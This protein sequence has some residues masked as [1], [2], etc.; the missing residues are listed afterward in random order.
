[1]ILIRGDSNSIKIN[2]TKNGVPY[3][4]QDLKDGDIF[5]FTIREAY[6]KKSIYQNQINYPELE[7]DIKSEDS[8]T[9]K[10]GHHVYDIE[11]RNDEG[12]VKTIIKADIEITEDVTY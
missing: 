10:L 9:F 6:T 11:Y 2:F 1:M 4:P 3:T 8:E 5:T 7:F 12:V